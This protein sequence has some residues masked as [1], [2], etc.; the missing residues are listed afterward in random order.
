MLPKCLRFEWRS[1]KMKQEVHPRRVGGL[2][3]T[4]NGSEIVS[5]QGP[6]GKLKYE[7]KLRRPSSRINRKITEVGGSLTC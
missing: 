6:S 4:R 2:E 3:V 7:M 1:D 5:C